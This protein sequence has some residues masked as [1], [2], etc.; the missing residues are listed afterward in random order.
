MAVL[1]LAAWLF[2][3]VGI[4]AGP[5]DCLGR[6]HPDLG[7]TGVFRSKGLERLGD[8]RGRPRDTAERFDQQRDEVD[9]QVGEPVPTAFGG[10]ALGELAE[11]LRELLPG[12]LGGKGCG[13]HGR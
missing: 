8:F 11:F 3:A 7:A 9:Q 10:N 6:V 12:S 2:G 5:V 1:R 4:G 13:V